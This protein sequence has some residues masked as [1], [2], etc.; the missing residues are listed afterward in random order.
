MLQRRGPEQGG[1]R[2]AF[3]DEHG[4]IKYHINKQPPESR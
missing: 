2:F 1:I 3:F 4:E